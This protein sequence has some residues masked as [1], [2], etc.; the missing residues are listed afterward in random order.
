MCWQ[1]VEEVVA[2]RGLT[3]MTLLLPLLP[4]PLLSLLPPLPPLLPL[5]LLLLLQLLL[6]LL[7][8]LQ[9]IIIIIIITIII[10]VLFLLIINEITRQLLWD[11]HNN[12]LTVQC[13]NNL[14][15]K[16]W[17]YYLGLRDNYILSDSRVTSSTSGTSPAGLDILDSLTGPNSSLL[18][19]TRH[20]LSRM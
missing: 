18:Q 3:L 14:C 17:Y 7:L 19:R 10:K 9:L 16:R 11:Y 2:K 4:P 20:Y 13:I 5:T 12:L 6:L 15:H 1:F 8:L